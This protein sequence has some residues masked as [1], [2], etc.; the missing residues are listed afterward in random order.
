[1]DKKDLRYSNYLSPDEFYSEVKE[2]I[3]KSVE[4]GNEIFVATLDLDHFNYVNDL[5]GYETGDL[6]LQKLTKHFSEVISEGCI[7]TRI[8]ADIFA[9]CLEYV[10]NSNVAQSFSELTDWQVELNAVLPEHYSLTASGGV[11]LVKESTAPVSSLIDK[12]N[13]ARQKA[14]GTM[15]NSFRFYDEKMSEELQWQKVVTFSMESAL[16]NHEF[17]MYLQPK[18]FIKNSQVVGAEA[19]VRWRSPQYGLIPP[20]RFIPILEQNGFVRQLDFFMLE[21]A[22]R[23]IKESAENGIPQIPISV[24]FSK[25][26]LTTDCL[27]E[28]IF[29][30]VNRMGINTKLIE[31][32]FTESLSV[33]G[34]ERLI[35]VVSDL[36]LLGFRVSLDDFGSAY[37]SLNCLKELPIDIIKIDKAFLNS[38]SNSEKGQMIIAKVVELIKSLRML[39]VMEGVETDEQVDFLRKMSCDFGQGYFYS[40]PMP[41]ADYIEYLK[42]SDIFIDIQ[43]YMEDQ[44]KTSDKSYLNVVPQEFQM[45]SW[46]LYTLG[47]NIDMGLMKGYLDGEATVQYVNDRAL[48]YLGYTR[49]EFREIFRNRIA[50]FTHPDDTETFIKNAQQLVKSGKP[51]KF[52]TRAIRKD[53]KIIVLQGRSSCVIDSQGRP[54]GIYAFQDV[55]EE[56]EA[57]RKL[58]NSLEEKIKELEE[59]AE[60]ERQSKEALSF[61]E[62]RYRVIVEQSND[63]MFD[64]DFDTDT[65]FLSDK[66]IKIF[67][68]TPIMEQL[69]TNKGIR[70]RIFPADLPG[71]ERWIESAYRKSGHSITEFRC[72]DVN[73]KYIW[74]RVHSTAICDENGNALRAVGLFS[75]VNAQKAELDALTF[76]SQRDPL[77]QL[78]NKEE[79]SIRINERL[80]SNPDLAGAFFMIDIDGFKELNDNLGHQLGDMVL[81]EFTHNVQEFFVKDSI[82]GR[83]GGDEI[84]VYMPGIGYTELEQNLKELMKSLRMQ[85]DGSAAKYNI[86]GSVGVSCYPMHG[87]TFEELYRYADIALYV[88]KRGGRDRFTIYQ[89]DMTSGIQGTKTPVEWTESFSNNYFCNDLPFRI[90]EMLY[91]TKDMDASVQMIL[92]LLGKRFGV[93]DV[94]IFQSNPDGLGANNTHEWRSAALSKD[95]G[96]LKSISYDNLGVYLSQYNSEGVYCCMDVRDAAPEVYEICMDQG[97]KS[98]LHCAIYNE[99]V[100]VG[101]IGFDM[102]TK[103][104]E[105]TSEEI[106]ILGYLSKILSVFLIKSNTVLKLNT[107]YQNYVE[108]LEN[109]NGYVYVVEPD[110]YQILYV[111]SAIKELG[112]DSGHTC[113]KKAFGINEPCVDCPMKGLNDFTHYATTEIYSKALNGWVN[114][115]ASKLK[116]EGGRDAVLLNCTD[117]SKFKGKVVNDK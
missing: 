13:Y 31:I 39:S 86:H 57:T 68:E 12:A 47:K 92:E 60:T 107:S 91:E 87:R 52:Q 29:Q 2:R 104:Y 70:E 82:V 18:V 23:F 33:E 71:F 95:I 3:N 61:S 36:K 19:L 79:T 78:L 74:I 62:E 5:F 17:E 20:D 43:N 101:F 67:G 102:C 28:R 93:D 53:G 24:N 114:A 100:M 8:H 90:F 77:T 84:A 116:W 111:N 16:K 9:F 117:I 25:M 112:V 73:Q 55:T 65:I 26:H 38:S 108:M 103:Y 41:S 22:C 40:R 56:L 27:V 21:E 106:A 11:I 99:G 64:W 1:M 48:E 32:E 76:K 50:A 97:I 44:A 110:T 4:I 115:A 45:D 109:L 75:D 6:V 113:Y 72:K 58:Q 15:S 98:L 54:V 42:K 37:S 34:F 7:F 69:T 96:T 66:Y 63:I 46:E 83:I 88:S 10:E 80:K 14:K 49:Q 59:A 85:Y 51:F 81:V 94:Y 35:E 89:P 105:W 30:T